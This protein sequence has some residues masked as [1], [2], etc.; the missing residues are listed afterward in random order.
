MK[1]NYNYKALSRIG[2]YSFE[3]EECSGIKIPYEYAKNIDSNICE[4]TRRLK[5]LELFPSM[6]NKIN[7]A[8]SKREDSTGVEKII[9]Q[10]ILSGLRA[11]CLQNDIKINSMCIG[12]L[13]TII[14]WRIVDFCKKHNI[15][16]KSDLYNI[17]ID[18][19]KPKSNFKFKTFADKSFIT[20]WNIENFQLLTKE[21]NRKKWNK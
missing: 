5:L 1:K 16:K 3:I 12:T 4:K 14:G 20:C 9:Y 11:H 21:E 8:Y 10:R 15:A 17:E 18:H 2:L 7:Y 13:E 6:K 19:I